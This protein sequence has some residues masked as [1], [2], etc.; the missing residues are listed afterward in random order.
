MSEENKTN[1][2]E[3][4]SQ[5][6]DNL[7]DYKEKKNKKSFKTK[8]ILVETI[9]LIIVLAGAY[10]YYNIQSEKINQINESSEKLEILNQELETCQ[11]LIT[12]DQV[13][14]EEYDYCRSLLRNFK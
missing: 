10:L 9:I 14:P 11:T 13:N 2:I 5:F 4:E 12:Q 1:D 8:V 6:E 3:N 7:E